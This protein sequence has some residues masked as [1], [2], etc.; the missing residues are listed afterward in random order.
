MIE[1]IGLVWFLVFNATF[2]TMSAISLR[3]VLLV[4]E[5]RVPWETTDLSQATDK[6]YPIML[7]RVH[8]PTNAVRTHNFSDL[9][10]AQIVV[11]PNHDIPWLKWKSWK[12]VHVALKNNHSFTNL[13]EDIL[14][15]IYCIYQI[16]SIL[17]KWSLSI[18]RQDSKVDIYVLVNMVKH[19]SDISV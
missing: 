1:M 14:I 10:I 15:Y 12:S 8:I 4:E 7:Y 18:Q 11:S 19:W 9:L 3:S 6:L 16:D 13:H 2:K 17:L 5:T